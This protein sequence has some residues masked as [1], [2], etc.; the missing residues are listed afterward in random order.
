MA[1]TSLPQVSLLNGFYG[2]ENSH[3]CLYTRN[4][5]SR[6]DGIIDLEVLRGLY[7][8][9]IYDTVDEIWMCGVVEVGGGRAKVVVW[10]FV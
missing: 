5:E 8:V 1:N 4:S 6:A 10:N 9:P 2:K 7:A 3:L